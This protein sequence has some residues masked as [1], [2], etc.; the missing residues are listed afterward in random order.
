MDGGRSAFNACRASLKTA[1]AELA[2][3]KKREAGARTA[4]EARERR[5][6]DLA[7]GIEDL[8]RQAGHPHDT[9]S[10]PQA[11]AAWNYVLWVVSRCCDAWLTWRPAL[12]T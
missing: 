7:A 12:R 9:C 1:R 10:F 3:L 11:G 5:L 4:L 6:A 2:A 8:T